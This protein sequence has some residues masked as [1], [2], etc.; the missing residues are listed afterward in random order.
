MKTYKAV[1]APREISI[2]AGDGPEVAMKHFQGIINKETV[3]G[4][5]FRSTEVIVVTEKAGCIFGADV[6]KS[7]YM[8]I[9]EKE[10]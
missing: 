7:H 8:L 6:S 9:F 4:W 5:R 10:V 3:G 1:S 2:P